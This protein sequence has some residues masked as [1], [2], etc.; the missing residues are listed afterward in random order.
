MSSASDGDSIFTPF[1]LDNGYF[2][3]T[4]SVGAYVHSDSWGSSSVTYDQEAAQVDAYCWENPTFLPVFPAGNDGDKP[5]SI[6]SEVGATTVNSPATS[7][8]CIAAGATQTTQESANLGAFPA[9]LYNAK[10]DLGSSLALSFRVVQSNFSAS[11]STL[12]SNT[13]SL[14]LTAPIDA[15]TAL[16]NPNELS[17]TVAM[18]ERGNCTFVEKSLAA[19]NAGAVAILVY[20][21]EVGAYFQAFSDGA[22]ASI[23]VMTIP[24]RLGQNIVAVLEAGRRA[25]ATFGPATE[26]AYGFENLASFSSQGPVNPDNRVKP[27]L[28]APGTIVSAAAGTTCDTAIFGGTSMATPVIASSA[29][30]VK[31]YF[32]D[33]YYPTGAPTPSNAL[34]PS[35]ALIKAVM[36]SGATSLQGY[37][38]DTGLPIDPPPSYRQGFGR[39]FLGASVFLQNNQYSP[40]AFQVV[41][42]VPIQS[43]DVHQYCIKANGGPLSITLVWT[44]YP[45]NPSAARSLVNDLDLVVRAEGLAGVSLLGN[46]GNVDASSEPDD[47]NN[48]ET[49]NLPAAPAGRMAVEVRGRDVQ[50][51]PGPQPYALVINGDF[52]GNIAAPSDGSGA[53]GNQCAVVVAVISKGPPSTTNQQSVVFE[54]STQAGNTNGVSYECKLTDS[55]GNIGAPG[56][57]DW[58]PCSS[59]VVYDNLPDGSYTFSVHAVGETIG[60][61]ASFTKDTIPPAVTLTARDVL[62]TSSGPSATFDFLANDTSVVSMQ[63]QI[64]VGGASPLQSQVIAGSVV[65]SPVALNQWYAC[66]TPQTL[67]WLLPGQWKFQVIASDAAG[68]TAAPTVISWAIAYDQS[69]NYL[70]VTDGPILTVPKRDITFKFQQFLSPSA[71]SNVA[72]TLP[73]EC[74][75][76]S[77]DTLPASMQSFAQPCTSPVSYGQPADGPYKFVARLSG[78]NS[79]PGNPIPDTWAVASFVLDST[80][81]KAVITSGPANNMAVSTHTATFAFTIN[82]EHSTAECSLQAKDVS[83]DSIPTTSCA[84]PVQFTNLTGGHYVFQLVPKDVVGNAGDAVTAEFIIDTAPPNVTSVQIPTAIRDATVTVAFTV[85]DGAAGSGVK[86]ITCRI[87][88]L[89]LAPSVASSVRPDDTRFDW[90]QCSSPWSL[91]G[92]VEGHYSFSMVAYDNAGLSA[93]PVEKEFWVDTVAPV[94]KITSGPSK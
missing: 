69:K 17:G 92:L 30:L 85:D 12:G 66:T 35:S 70:R 34:K 71:G 53:S 8:N 15:C 84:S 39:V 51:S 45:G 62:P 63:C 59:P 2:K 55:S 14:A 32:E 79:Q 40:K 76:L 48:I 83:S 42:K 37:E 49:I 38:A 4:T 16:Q 77:G 29:L 21:S 82:E 80:P 61:S 31:Q 24:R 23:P 68:N 54:L 5:A 9:R 93:A 57:I 86:N 28:V 43:G 26:P 10:V 22:Q 50:A 44:D 18:V 19:Q 1:D 75:L 87:K 81:P 7:K 88:P 74:A 89:T 6:A 27:D 91:A 72:T 36:V 33:G 90:M 3:Y 67:G 60:T 52:T 56:T 64:S 73:V 94:P 65:A 13:Y 11:V 46:G 47:V 25:N 58:K 41:D 78:D 20:D